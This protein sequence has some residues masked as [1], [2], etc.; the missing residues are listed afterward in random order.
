[1]TTT[2]LEHLGHKVKLV[3]GEYL[4]SVDYAWFMVY[5]PEEKKW[6]EYGLS[7]LGTKNGFTTPQH[8]KK[9]VCDDWGDIYARL[10]ENHRTYKQ[11][12]TLRRQRGKLAEN[13][14]N[15]V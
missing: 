15:L 9:L 13:M 5:L 6:R 2:I 11:R 14:S 3:H 10:L 7:G 12:K 4:R 8:K 1:M